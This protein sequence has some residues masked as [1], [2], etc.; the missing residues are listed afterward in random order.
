MRIWPRRIVWQLTC[1]G[2]PSIDR[3]LAGQ[4]EVA[5]EVLLARVGGDSSSMPSVTSTMH[6]LHLPCLRQDVGT[7]TPSRSACSKSECP[8]RRRSCCPLMVSVTTS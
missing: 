1:A 5:R 2:R 7:R 6:S 3:H 4:P 8:G